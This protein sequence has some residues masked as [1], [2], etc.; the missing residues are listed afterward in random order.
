MKGLVIHDWFAITFRSEQVEQEFEDFQENSQQL[1]RELE[2]AIDQAEKK[3]RELLARNTRCQLDI[4]KYEQNQNLARA[5][6][7]ELESKVTEY[8]CEEKKFIKNIRDL[9]QKNDDF[10]R[11]NR[12]VSCS[13]FKLIPP[14]GS[15]Y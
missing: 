7:E 8:K 6:I 14:L 3:E 2:A 15:A 10:E 4:E 1:E 5:R 12:C 9:E 13:H 11:E